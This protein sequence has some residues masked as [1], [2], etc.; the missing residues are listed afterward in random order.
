VSYYAFFKGGCFQAHLLV[1]IT[2]PLP[3]TLCHPLGTLTND[4]GCFPLDLGS[5]HP[6]SVYPFLLSVFGVLKA[7]RTLV[8]YPISALPLK[9][10]TFLRRYRT[11]YLNSFRGKPAISELVK[12]F[13]P[14]HK[15]SR[16]LAT[17]SGAVLHIYLRDT[18]TCSWLARS[19][20]GLIMPTLHIFHSINTTKILLRPIQTRFRYASS[21]IGLSSQT[22]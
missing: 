5:S 11:R 17:C 19:V 16:H 6:K 20:S 2:R 14:N 22:Q 3:C 15:S 7:S 1:V 10:T 12:P 18:S 13:T 4:L 8:L 21:P 9:K